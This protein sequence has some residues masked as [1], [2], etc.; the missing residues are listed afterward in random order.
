MNHM[1]GGSK[2]SHNLKQNVDGTVSIH[3][4]DLLDVNYCV[5][6]SVHTISKNR[7]ITHY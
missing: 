7:Y 2:I 3:T 5:N 1:R 6:F 4:C